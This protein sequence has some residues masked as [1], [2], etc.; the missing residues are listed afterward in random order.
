MKTIYVTSAE[1]L[2]GKTSLII[3]LG[4]HLQRSGNLIGYIKPLNTRAQIVE[5]QLIDRDTGFV[6]QMLGLIDPLSDM[7]PLALTPHIIEQEMRSPQT[8]L[9]TQIDAAY[10][11][12]IRDQDV[13]W[14]E[15]GRHP[16]EGATLGLAAG[17]L[18][19][20][21]DAQVLGVI[22]YTDH[23]FVDQAMALQS[24]FGQRLLGLVINAVPRACIPLVQQ[25]AQPFLEQRG[26]PVLAVLPQERLLLSV[27]V[28]EVVE[29]L[30]GQVIC[31]AGQMAELVEYLMV[32]AMTA[33]SALTYFRSRPNK[34]VIT[35]GDRHDVQLA[36]LETSTR[37][38]ILTGQQQPSDVVISRAEQVGVPIIVVEPDTLTTVQSLEQIFGKTSLRQPRK[39]AHLCAMLQERFDFERFYGMIGLRS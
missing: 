39:A 16:F 18:I 6:R 38:L 1:D 14:V 26:L 32:G 36:A 29:H 28:Q 21:W 31:C 9:S 15:G 23:L 33:S 4:Q 13:M 7:S 24:L 20:M 22:R 19:A 37:C 8:G 12:L 3:G 25:I 2:G 17:H 10:R 11:R 30:G 27:S 35:G 5:E 34:A